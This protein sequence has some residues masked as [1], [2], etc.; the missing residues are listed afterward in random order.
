MLQEQAL[1]QQQ[2]AAHRMDGWM[3]SVHNFVGWELRRNAA[4]YISNRMS[5]ILHDFCCAPRVA[6]QSAKG[7]SIYKWLYRVIYNNG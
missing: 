2:T 6:L 7:T 3:D 5:R 1:A 4:S